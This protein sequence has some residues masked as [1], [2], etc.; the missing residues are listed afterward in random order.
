[1]ENTDKVA[2]PSYEELVKQLDNLYDKLKEVTEENNALRWSL[3]TTHKE[4]NDWKNLSDKW[5]ENYY[6]EHE[7]AEKL[8]DDLEESEKTKT[9]V[10]INIFDKEEIIENCTVQILSNSKTGEISVGWWR[11]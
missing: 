4:M 7:R 6:E 8:Y 2:K 3:T 9:K 5:Q 10:K 1:M 11:N